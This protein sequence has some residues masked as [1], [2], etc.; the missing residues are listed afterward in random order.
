MSWI[1][2]SCL[3]MFIGVLLVFVGVQVCRDSRS[4]HGLTATA[5]GPALVLLGIIL[6]TPLLLAASVL[7]GL[8]LLMS[9]AE[10]LLTD[11]E[12]DR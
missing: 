10:D 6:C 7:A 9:W 8:L 11:S 12:L 1:L 5:A 2:S 3:V 4:S